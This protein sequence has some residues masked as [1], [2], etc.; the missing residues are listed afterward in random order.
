MSLR[1]YCLL[2]IVFLLS[3]GAIRAQTASPFVSGVWSGNVTP[4]SVTVS[5]RLNAVGLRARLVVSTNDRLTPA[6]FST[7]VTTAAASGNIVKLDVNGLQ[8]ATDYFYGIEVNSVVRTETISRGKFRTFPQGASSFRLAFASCGDTR[9][10][11]QRV[12]DAILAEQ[13]QLF[14][15]VGDMHYF[16]TNTT[17][18][19]D[20][21]RNY[22]AVLNHKNQGALYRGLATAYM[23]DDHDFAG[24]D[25]NGT[26]VGTAAARQAYREYVP[27]YPLNSGGGTVGQSFTVGRVRVIMTDLRSGSS[28]QSV[29]ESAAKTRLGVLQKAW[30][31]QELI[32]ARDA[33]FPM[34]L[35][36]CTVPWIA[37]GKTG[38]D[39]WGGY[40]TERVEL[41]NFIKDNR[42]KNLVL[43]AG[44]MHALA[45]DGGGN[46]DYATGGGAPLVVLHGA[47]LTRPPSSKGGPYAAGPI[48]GVGQYGLLEI[49]DTG[50]SS[51]QVRYVGKRVD[52]GAKLVFQFSASVAGIVPS[53]VSGPVGGTDKV[54]VNVSSRGRVAA[55]GDA[56]IV[57]FVVA[58]TGSRSILM[59]GIGPSLA[60]FGVGDAL[61]KPVLTLY[62]GNGA[63]IA[64]NDNW[65]TNDA[66]RLRTA[67]ERAGAF[68]LLGE[69][70]SDAALLAILAPGAY[71]MVVTGAEGATGSVMAE[72]YEVP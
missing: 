7:V 60:R 15:N 70:A 23:W 18:A 67:F 8:P 61:A 44:D 65:N 11:D 30:F 41:A 36:V 54:F 56:L 69:A 68:P 48:L 20:Y 53:G 10:A 51:I 26:A 39:T 52:E 57:G 14:I 21:R 25:S 58:G 31:K 34:I 71:T 5:V 38:D 29:A 62:R 17:V 16:D 40:A 9:D 22:D 35:W 47:P 43:L 37:E 28:A 33:G 24:D 1:R 45:F 4:S 63:V 2:L 50:G 42:V 55:A 59:R 32:S 12:Y 49:T 66:V 3:H 72:A 27:H 19:G 6:V 46:S 13:P 64:S